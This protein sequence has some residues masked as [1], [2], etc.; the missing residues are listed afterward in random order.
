MRDHKG[1]KSATVAHIVCVLGINHDGTP[2]WTI[3]DRIQFNCPPMCLGV[4]NE[5]V[6]V[7]R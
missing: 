4:S 5:R 1:Y 2:E 7:G 6:L 3:K